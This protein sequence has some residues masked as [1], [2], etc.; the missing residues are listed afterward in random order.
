MR[1]SLFCG[2][3]L[4]LLGVFGGLGC[5]QTAGGRCVQDSDCT[6]GHCSFYGEQSTAGRCVASVVATPQD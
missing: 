5:L 1:W 2:F 4:L 3:S 6:T